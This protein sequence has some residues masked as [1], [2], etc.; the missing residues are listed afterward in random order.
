MMMIQ[1][2]ASF[3]QYLGKNLNILLRIMEAGS[4]SSSKYSYTF[5]M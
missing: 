4:A 3:I 1:S 5:P 2:P